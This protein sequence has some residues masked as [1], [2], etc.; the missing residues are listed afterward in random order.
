MF[1]DVSLF[2]ALFFLDT[3]KSSQARKG[4]RIHSTVWIL[5]KYCLRVDWTLVSN[6]LRSE[7]SS[8][9]F[10]VHGTDPLVAHQSQHR[11]ASNQGSK[12]FHHFLCL[13]VQIY[14]H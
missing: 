14:A 3:F 8:D 13:G 2:N 10:S 1:I 7:F 11:F 9:A 5:S 4:R 6:K 12:I